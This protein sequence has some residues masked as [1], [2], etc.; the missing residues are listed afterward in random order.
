MSFLMTTTLVWT[1]INARHK[2]FSEFLLPPVYL[3]Y[4][5]QINIFKRYLVLLLS[6]SETSLAPNFLLSNR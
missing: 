4:F 5:C 6:Y 3:I 2:E 1:L